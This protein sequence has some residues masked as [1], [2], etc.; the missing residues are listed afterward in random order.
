[1]FLQMASF[2]KVYVFFINGFPAAMDTIGRIETKSKK[3]VAFLEE[4]REA[5]STGL[6]LS[7]LLIMPIQRVPRYRSDPSRLRHCRGHC[8]Y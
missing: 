3:F 4:T 7:D 2:L 5:S 6:G 8:A 1:M